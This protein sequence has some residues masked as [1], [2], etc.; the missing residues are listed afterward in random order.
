MTE[1]KPYLI[2]GFPA[3]SYYDSKSKLVAGKL[4]ASKLT[5][6]DIDSR[7]DKDGDNE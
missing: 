3:W 2:N 4:D 6:K 1:I 7:I 5:V